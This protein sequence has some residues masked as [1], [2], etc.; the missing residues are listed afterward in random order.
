MEDSEGAQVKAPAFQFYPKQWLGDDKILLMSWD[1]RAMHMHL[2]CIAWQQEPPCTL[3]NDDDLIRQWIGNPKDWPRLKTQIFRAW[4]LDGDRW[5]QSGLLTEF[6]KQAAFRDSR[7]A[8]AAAKWKKHAHASEV[9]CITDALLSSSSSSNKTPISPSGDVSVDVIEERTRQPTE[10][11]PKKRRKREMPTGPL[12]EEFETEFWPLVWLKDNKLDACESY[13]A[14]R[15]KYPK[16]RIL[17]GLKKQMPE[18]VA[19]VTRGFH[20]LPTTWLNKESFLNE[21][22]NK[23]AQPS[24][25]FIPLPPAKSLDQEFPR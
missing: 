12:A 3:P 24:L 9:H 22:A 25:S 5:I 15:E 21:G 20:L 1:A 17:T 4:K 10:E 19:K 23:S 18:L 16:E 6:N 8:G 14:K 2:M 13:I 11:K 7:K